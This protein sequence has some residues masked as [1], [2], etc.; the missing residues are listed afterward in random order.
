MTDNIV[1]NGILI[2]WIV[3]S[4]AIFISLFFIVAPYGRHHRSG[5][6]ITVNST[7]GWI[8]MES[9]SPLIFA[10]CFILGS[11]PVSL[12]S[13][14]FL[15]LWE[16]HYIHRA[17]IY[18]FS[19]KN[20]DGNMPL[21]VVLSGIFF[22]LVN[23]SLNGYYVF[24]L[25]GGYADR[26][27]ADPRFIIGAGIFITGFVINRQ[28]DYT[29]SRLRQPGRATYS[30]PYGGLYNLVSCPNYFGEILIWTGWAIAT[31]SLAG[32]SFA[33]WTAANLVPRA[34]AHHAWYHEKFP[35][36]PSGRKALIPGIW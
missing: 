25:S 33:V 5:W 22:N 2:G 27:L 9:A 35:E 15:L 6:G 28:A 14:A 24:S 23:A 8:I 3:L 29:L 32:L 1:Y 19:L 21:S 17:F 4:V 18:P 13:W 16:A 34:R 36:Y 31:W 11:S 26:W 7:L 12:T 10:L 20:A 30:I